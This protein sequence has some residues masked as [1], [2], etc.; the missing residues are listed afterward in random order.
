MYYRDN[1]ISRIKLLNCVGCAPR[2][3][4][5]EYIEVVE[6][7]KEFSIHNDHLSAA[8]SEQGFLKAITLKDS[9]VTVPL[10]LDFAR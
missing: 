3:E 8:F 4:G 5:F 6:E 9:S 7:A 2:V 10:H 1:V